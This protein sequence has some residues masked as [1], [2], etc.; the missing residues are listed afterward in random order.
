[1]ILEITHTAC[2]SERGNWMTEYSAIADVSQLLI[3]EMQSVLVPDV[4]TSND[5]IG[6]CSPAEHNDISL[7][8][9]LYDIMESE[10]IRRSSMITSGIHNRMV[11]PPIYLN[12]YYMIT[13]YFTGNVK[14]KM[15]GEQE[16]MGRV[17]QYFH[18]Y[19]L[20]PIEKVSPDHG[21]AI[22]LRIE[23]LRLDME[24][25]SRI[26]NFPNEPYRTSLF[27]KVSPVMI[28]SSRYTDITRVSQAEINVK[29]TEGD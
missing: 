8:I 3:Q 21:D 10:E 27:Y 11:Y 15:A 18:D 19:P 29:N 14:Y 26:W 12:L 13:P 4:V 2:I 5:K 17:I 9:F 25:K 28:H 16:I 6:L 7:G 1:M 20:I 22:D 24:Q 23:L